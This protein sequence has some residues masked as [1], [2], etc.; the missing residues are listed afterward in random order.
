MT[1]LIILVAVVA[2]I[3]WG[4]I[5][6][7]RTSENKKEAMADLKLQQDQIE[8]FDIHSLVTDEIADPGLRS[9]PGATGIPASVLLKTWKDNIETA[10]GCPSRDLL[11]FVVTPGLDPSEALDSDVTLVCDA[12]TIAAQDAPV[13]D[14]P[15][16][17]TETPEIT[18]DHD[19][20]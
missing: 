12:D 20:K 2:L 4:V 13:E 19:S 17:A 14:Q 11:S 7:R 1:P 9:I 8:P 10:N 6:S 5:A 3:V 18:D 15:A 16:I